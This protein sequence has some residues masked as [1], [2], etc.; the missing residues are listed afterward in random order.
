M[1]TLVLFLA[2]LLTVSSSAP[3]LAL[4]PQTRVHGTVVKPKKVRLDPN[5]RGS[6]PRRPVV[7]VPR[8]R[9]WPNRPACRAAKGGTGTDGHACK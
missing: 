2:V 5:L 1:R 8:T 3:A 6:R 7:K 9:W 4:V